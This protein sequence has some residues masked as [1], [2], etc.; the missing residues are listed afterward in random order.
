MSTS[1]LDDELQLK[2]LLKYG[3]VSPSMRGNC[4]PI[5][6]ADPFAMDF[7]RSSPILTAEKIN[8]TAVRVIHSRPEAVLDVP[9]IASNFYSHPLSW[10]KDNVLAVGLGSVVF[11]MNMATDAVH[12]LVDLKKV[13]RNR[14]ETS[15][16]VRAVKWCTV[17]GLTHYLAVGTDSGVR[18]YDATCKKEVHTSLNVGGGTVHALCWNDA[19][20][21]LTVGYDTGKLVSLDWRS[22]S[23][24]GMTRRGSPSSSSSAS[25]CNIAWNPEGTCLASGRSDGFFY[26]EKPPSRRRSPSYI[27][28]THGGCQGTGMVSLSA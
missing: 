16:H 19:L 20:Q 18:L 10:S 23:M 21:W 13:S 17:E 9:D 24:T 25:V 4:R 22:R 7:L 1:D 2:S 14:N 15:S 11:I 6:A 3:S 26:D 28:I 12:E 8:A 5:V 27:G